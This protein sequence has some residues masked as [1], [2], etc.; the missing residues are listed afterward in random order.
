[1][2]KSYN[3]V[4]HRSYWTCQGRGLTHNPTIEMHDRLLAPWRLMRVKMRYS[5]EL[6]LFSR[7]IRRS[8]D[9]TVQVFGGINQAIERAL[10]LL[11][12]N[13]CSVEVNVCSKECQPC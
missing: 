9:Q 4:S 1:M 8:E 13:G 2:N 5:I 3:Y 11:F 10:V 6:P 12:G 7:F